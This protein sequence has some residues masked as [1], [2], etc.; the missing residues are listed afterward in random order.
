M[1]FPLR[2]SA[3]D[4]P[5]DISQMFKCADENKLCTFP[6]TQDVYFGTNGSYASVTRTEGVWCEVI[7]IGT[8]PAYGTPKAC[9]V[10][11]GGVQ[12]DRN[13][14]VYGNDPIDSHTYEV[15]DPVTV[16]DIEERTRAGYTFD[17][18]NTKADGT[19]TH[20]DVGEIFSIRTAMVRLYAEWIPTGLPVES[21]YDGTGVESDP[22]QVATPGQLDMVRNYFGEGVY[23]QLTADIDLSDYQSGAGWTP[24]GDTNRYF[25][26]SMDG[27]GYKITNLSIN[28]PTDHYVGLFGVTYNSDITNMKLED[29]DIKGG[30]AVG[31]LAGYNGGTI[32][33]SSV[34]GTITGDES[35]GGLIGYNE[36]AINNSYTTGNV[37]GGSLVGGLIGYNTGSIDSSYT[38][39][40]VTGSNARIGG[41]VG[42]NWGGG[43][44]NS[45]T[46]GSVTGGS[47]AGG[48]VGINAGTVTYSYATG[49][50][51]GEEDV[52]GLIGL[53]QSTVGQ[54]FYDLDTSNQSDTGKGDGKS[55][56]EMKTEG[57]YTDAGWDFTSIWGIDASRNHGY[58]YLG[59][60]QKIVT[61]DGNGN[62]SGMVP[63]DNNLYLQG[64]AVGVLRPEEPFAK[65]GYTFAGWNTQADGNGTNYAAGDTFTMGTTKVTLYAKWTTVPGE[66]VFSGMGTESDPYQIATPEQLDRVRS[67]L[68]AGLY[69]KLTA[70]I[71]LSEYQTGEGWAPIGSYDDPFQ[72]HM[73]GNG[74]KITNLL[75]HGSD[76][77]LGLFATIGQHA[78][79]TGMKLEDV[80]IKG[81]SGVGALAGMNNGAI[82]N[83]Y[84]TGSVIGEGYYIGGL[85]SRNEG[86]I[87]NSY[88]AGSVTGEALVGGLT[89]RNDGTIGNS[90]ATGSVTGSEVVGGLTG[91]ND[92]TI[93]NSYVTGSVTGEALVGGLTGENDGGT[94]F[95]SY[96]AGSV[97]GNSDVGGLVGENYG[98]I[99]H[100]F[101]D[102]ETTRQSDT[103]KGAGKSTQEMKT[104]STYADPSWDFAGI[105]GINPSHNNG[106]PYL[107]AIHKFVTYDGNGSNSGSVPTDSRS[108]SQGATAAVYGNTGNLAKS[109]Y[110]FAGWNTQADGNGTNYGAGDTFTMGTANVTLYAKWQ[111]ANIP[112]NGSTTSSGWTPSSDK[113]TSSNG[114]LTLPVGKS[115]EVS[116]DGQVKIVIP[117]GAA[118]KDL[119]ITIEV[120]TD[121][122][123]L[124]TSQD[125]WVTPIYEILKNVTENLDKEV[126]L[127]F[128]FDPDSLK[129]GQ[130]PSVFFYDD[131]EQTWVEVGGVV[132][133]N[134]IEVK[135]NRFAK[136]AV[137]AIGQE[138]EVT[139]P[140]TPSIRLSDISGHWAEMNMK[141]AVSLSIVSGY[142]DGTF[143]PNATVTRAEFA[144]M[145]M[146]AM[147]PEQAGTA[148]TFAD[149]EQI[150]VWAQEAVAQAVQAGIIHGYED[151]TFRPNAQITRAEM[152]VVISNAL[153]QSAQATTATR[154]TDN[155]DIPAW[156]TGA[157]AAMHKLGIIEGKGA[158]RFAPG[159]HATRAEAVTVI[160]N[161]LAQ[162][163]K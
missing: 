70:D 136:F 147:K 69:F 152:A 120:V 4:L 40:S 33:D 141:Q 10:A 114:T 87:D 64:E 158:S 96:A 144:V 7:S 41:L 94:I 134:T 15:G 34:A 148:L 142:P 5:K 81:Y 36:G 85:V 93:G 19:G 108:Y 55:T 50:V 122:E 2:V 28:R 73:D 112:G 72:G 6:G 1:S 90:Y 38:T 117:A 11:Q 58:P 140:A 25:E 45:Y 60:I 132:D 106:Y 14:L 150:G 13:G 99:S 97:T 9:Y 82:D 130:A 51:S 107:R 102:M 137:F 78:H 91:R 115:G 162:Q 110:T 62:D 84:A 133:G 89:G 154:F 71:D 161:M 138:V 131:I 100:S 8:D 56:S 145:L 98:T 57:T 126:T 22:Y 105:W 86:T 123:K 31:G 53:N 128:T 143:K 54:S 121:T 47:M 59:A 52:G 18:W 61:Y 113:V 156:A 104:P 163:S 3:A 127:T 74:H 77:F 26:G 29:V 92:G 109:G 67:Y 88:V 23:F 75:I 66:S 68:N 103:D 21:V 20:Y 153:G 124:L 95:N 12:Y 76:S 16:L 37:T 155:E 63:T 39:G 118:R 17:G 83:S 43:I 49:R 146:N 80:S 35:A 119:K 32:S 157:V 135:V 139:E 101:Y 46:T 30:F 24:I 79:V 159:D 65:S 129:E 44:S 149:K 151:G 160:L 116:L 42:E 27:N 48:V 111:V 125:V